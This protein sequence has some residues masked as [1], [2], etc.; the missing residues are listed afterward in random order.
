[1]EATGDSGGRANNKL[2]PDPDAQGSHSS[3]ARDQ[4]GN[5]FKYETY[6]RTSTSHNNP[7]KRFDDGNPDGTPGAP[8]E[9]KNGVPIPTP[10]VQGKKIPEG[11]RPP[12]PDEIPRNQRFN[13]TN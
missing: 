2:K 13:G 4:N 9:N 1:V 10:H 8:H 7:E 6:E 11:A 12:L 5:I 3:F